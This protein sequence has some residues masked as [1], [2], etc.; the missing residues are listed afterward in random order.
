MNGSLGDVCSWELRINETDF[1]NKHFRANPS[2]ITTVYFNLTF[3]EAA[4]M[5]FYLMLGDT[6]KNTTNIT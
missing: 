6:I 2:N 5:T 4:N 1:K 3:L